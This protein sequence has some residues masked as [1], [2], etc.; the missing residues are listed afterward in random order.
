MPTLIRLLVVLIVLAGLGFAGMI[1]LTMMVD[2]GE[3]DI[4]VKIPARELVPAAGEGGGP[5]DLDNLPDPVNV[6]PRES[7]APSDAPSAASDSSEVETV[8]APGTE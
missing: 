5:I 2:P 8:V 4:T 7:V 3:K 6:V 1:G